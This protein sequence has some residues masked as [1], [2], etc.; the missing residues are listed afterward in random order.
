MIT[1]LTG[2]NDFAIKA[3]IDR[4]KDEFIKA[5]TADGLEQYTAKELELNR[6]ADLISGGSL[7]S[8]KRLVI[9]RD[10]G[11]NKELA[12]ALAEQVGRV[13]DS[14]TLVISQLKP[15]KRTRWFGILKAHAK[16]L[17]SQTGNALVRWLVDSAKSRG[18]KL[19]ESDAR[20]LITL[21]GEDQWRLASELDKLAST[22]QPVSAKL[23]DELVEP[24][25]EETIFQLI[26][27]VVRGEV[28]PA[29]ELYDKL[30]LSEIDPHQFIGTLAWQFNALV[31]IKTSKD[32]PSG[33][34]AGASGLSPFVIDRIKPVARK[35]SAAQL[36]GSMKL[37]LEADF[38]M[39]HTGIDADQRAKLLI[40][41]LGQA[42]S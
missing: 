20:H 24:S 14:T 23:M 4:L 33:Q 39:K 12:E 11:D 41:Q 7:F 15:D 32:K 10:I 37:V 35:L 22:G 36:R 6:V 17:Q 28:E 21:V 1:F 9:V 30:R 8:A 29:I 31:V 2:D 19:S 40:G 16:I 25:S 18:L 38:E 13:D 5:N 27:M 26:D 42:I 3:E 34:I